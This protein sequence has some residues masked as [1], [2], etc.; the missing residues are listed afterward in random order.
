MY[1]CKTNIVNFT[2]IAQV[3]FLDLDIF[4]LKNNFLALFCFSS[5]CSLEIRFVGKHLLALSEF[6]AAAAESVG[7]VALQNGFALLLSSAA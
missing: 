1:T 7:N 2:Q 4:S 5:S 6:V 3:V